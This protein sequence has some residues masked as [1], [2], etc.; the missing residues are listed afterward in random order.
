MPLFGRRTPAT[1]NLDQQ[2]VFQLSKSRIP[3]PRQLKYIGHFVKGR[4]RLTLYIS[5]GIMIG[6]LVFLS[7]LWYRKHV[8]LIP[9]S[10]GRYIE[11][12]VGNPQYINPLYSSLNNVDADLD[13]LIF[14]RLFKTNSSG[15]IENDLVSNFEIS[16]DQKTYTVHLK[17]ATWNDANPLTADDVVF[18]FKLIQNPDYKSPLR[19][20]FVDVTI[21]KVDDHTITFNL[22]EAYGRFTS[23]LNFGILP[24]AL[25]EGV[26]S[27]MIPLAELNLK[28][29]G[30]GPYQL[31]S[32]VK[33]STGTIRS[34]T[35][36]RNPLYYDTAPW[37]DEIVFKFYP[38][39]EEMIA[40]LNNGQINGL[41]ELP[42]E[43]ADTIVAKNALNYHTIPGSHLTALF[44]NMKSKSLIAEAPIRRALAALDRSTIINTLPERTA[45]PALSLLP[46]NQPGYQ[47][48]NVIS[49]EEAG[50]LLDTSGWKIRTLTESDL[51]WAKTAKAADAGNMTKLGLGSWRMKGN[52]G[53]AI[54]LTTPTSMKLVAEKV[55]EHWK[56]LGILVDIKIVEDSAVQ[57]QALANRDFEVLLYAE[58]LDIGDP[59]PFWGTDGP[60][61]IPGYTK[62]DVD[63]WLKEARISADQSVIS[64]RYKKFQQAMDIDV[65]AI[66]LYWHTFIYPQPKKLKGFSTT[67]LNEPSDRFLGVRSWYF[68]VER[69][70]K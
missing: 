23:L 66:P 59:F 70:I 22:P 53:I 48:S 55:A 40:A 39:S 67:Y 54:T 16:D 15:Q 27:E 31:K 49:L 28:P 45:A 36:E 61:N 43:V 1:K 5:L 17:E 56:Q 20:R 33:N 13:R 30:S 44:F 37:L 12:I 35:I 57:T 8:E 7:I 64:D 52:Q 50:Q 6:S 14:S 69:K 62:T 18:T 29:M 25:W 24:S 9:A 2:L 10:G 19:A 11:G 58:D 3:S 42:I 4:E 65:P 51:T 60:G 34:Y 46:I 47:S 38:S 32:L 21:E 68:N 41:A 63:T 26:S